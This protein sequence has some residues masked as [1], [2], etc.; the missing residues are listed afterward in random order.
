MKHFKWRIDLWTGNTIE[1][2]GI[3]LGFILMFYLNFLS[4][5]PLKVLLL[6][7]SWLCF[8]YFPHCLAHYIAGRILGIKFQYYFVGT[9]S[10]IKM[11]LPL[12]TPIIR[13]IPV[14]GIKIDKASTLNISRYRMAIM[15]S[16]GVLASMLCPLI[17]FIYSLIYLD[18]LAKSFTGVLTFSNIIFTIY[19]SFKVGDFSKA[20]KAL[21]Q[22]K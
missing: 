21:R 6:I 9:S 11:G 17:P 18:Y 7:I 3:S 5:Y 10:L 16:S 1:V 8:W 4:D 19:F 22:T 20:M 12:V 15:Y 13:A 14:L 2:A